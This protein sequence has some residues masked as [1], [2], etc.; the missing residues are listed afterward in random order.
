[1]IVNV[2]QAVFNTYMITRDCNHTLDVAFRSVARVAK[3][4]NVA[5]MNRLQA[6]DELVNED[7]L[8]IFQGRHHAGA[9]DLNRLIEEDDEERRHSQGDQDIAHPANQH[10]SSVAARWPTIR[11]DGC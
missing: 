2:N 4:H 6:I 10:G 3:D 7:A 9:L 5:A 1:M 11:L 8:L